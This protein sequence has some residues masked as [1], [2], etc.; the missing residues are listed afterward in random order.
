MRIGTSSNGIFGSQYA[1]E[2]Y[3][4][5]NHD[6]TNIPAPGARDYSI[7]WQTL[8]GKD[9]GAGRDIS[10]FYTAGGQFDQGSAFKAVLTWNMI[11]AP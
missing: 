5:S 2:I 8:M 7:R 1:R 4:R 3:D 10:V 11:F 6:S 9:N